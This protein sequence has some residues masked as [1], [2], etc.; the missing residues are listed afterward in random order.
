MFEVFRMKARL[1]HKKRRFAFNYADK[2]K[3]VVFIDA[4]SLGKAW[5]EFRRHHE[6]HAKK[7]DFI[8]LG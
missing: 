4:T 7:K 6:M 1:P 2:S 5:I 3:P 8:V